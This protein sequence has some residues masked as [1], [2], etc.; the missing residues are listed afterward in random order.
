MCM[1]LDIRPKGLGPINWW[2]VCLW[3]REVSTQMKLGGGGGFCMKK[4]WSG[5]Y[6]T[7]QW[8]HRTGMTDARPL[9]RGGKGV[10]VKRDIDGEDHSRQQLDGGGVIFKYN[11]TS[12][13]PTTLSLHNNSDSGLIISKDVPQPTARKKNDELGMKF[14]DP[15]VPASVS[16]NDAALIRS[17]Y[18]YRVAEGIFD[19]CV[20]SRELPWLPIQ[21][22]GS[23][24]NPTGCCSWPFKGAIKRAWA[25]EFSQ[26]W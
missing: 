21:S 22:R 9:G 10:I 24:S 8:W 2:W 6:C 4:Y 16:A 12:E 26:Q 18:F 14:F 1:W 25:E 5:G 3:A 19:D 11:D 15:T 20:K 7:F 23:G 13:T 17:G